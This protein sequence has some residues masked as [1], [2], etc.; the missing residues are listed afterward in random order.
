MYLSWKLAHGQIKFRSNQARYVGKHISLMSPSL[1]NCLI[2]Y[3]AKKSGGDSKSH[4]EDNSDGLS[5]V[6]PCQGRAP[7]TSSPCTSRLCHL[8]GARKGC[9]ELQD[10]PR[11]GTVALQGRCFFAISFPNREVSGMGQ[12]DWGHASV[13]RPDTTALRPGPG[14]L[15]PP[16]FVPSI[17]LLT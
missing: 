6:E 15:Q 7:G 9:T 2:I 3:W 5:P 12:I 1:F 16:S 4:G 8:N 13:C 14:A 11:R 17:L 10:R